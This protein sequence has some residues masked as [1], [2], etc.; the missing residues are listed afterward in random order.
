MYPTVEP[1]EIQH[2]YQH[3]LRTYAARDIDTEAAIKRALAAA[4]SLHC[5]QG[6]D[7]G[8]FEVKAGTLDGG[9]IMATGNYPG[10]ARSGDELR[11][12]LEQVL[13]L[14]PGPHRVNLH[15][16]YA[17]TGGKVVDRDALKPSH[18][19][20]WIAWAKKRQAGLDF[21]PTYFAHPKANDGF[22]LSHRDDAIRR[23]WVRH[24]IASR[25]IGEA[26]GRELGTPCVVNSWIPDGA[27]DLTV[28]RAG[29][30]KRLLQSLD[31]IYDPKLK[32][33]ARLCV[34]AVE[35]KLFGIG[36]EEFVVGSHEFYLGYAQRKGVAPCLDMGHFHPTEGVADKLSAMLLFHK[37]ILLHLSRSIRWDSDHIVIFNDDL[38]AVFLELVRAGALERVFLALDY[39]DASVNRI[40][41]YVIGA[42]AVR[43]ALLY[44]LLEPL[45]ALRELE[46]QG[47]HAQKLALLE[48]CKTLPFDAVWN[49]LCRRASAPI[50]P[51]WLNEVEAY[52]KDVLSKRQR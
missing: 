32:I 48:E 37:R 17:E 36:S 44:A 47:K 41:A 38:R 9:G 31:E 20:K 6:D 25:R 8:G 39:F 3:A 11:S 27:K 4:L 40:A 23:F 19:S 14:L 30:R 52:E 51:G 45:P 7:V 2:L 33:D 26:L 50:G 28:D 29:F 5:W 13:R 34:D 10:R 49:E 35:G 46:A 21:N 1:V 12:D 42:R 15:A 18:F 24:G 22:T 16:S 43:K